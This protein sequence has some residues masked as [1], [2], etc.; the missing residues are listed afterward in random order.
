MKSSSKLTTNFAACN[1][2]LNRIWFF[3]SVN[4]K[5]FKTSLVN[6]LYFGV[7]KVNLSKISYKKPEEKTKNYI[8]YWRKTEMWSLYDIYVDKF[9]CLKMKGEIC[10]VY[11]DWNNT[12]KLNIPKLLCLMEEIGNAKTINVVLEMFILY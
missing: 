10:N 9:A 6:R 1:S 7:C 3:S 2:K 4:Q 12:R 11:Q 5:F 8:K